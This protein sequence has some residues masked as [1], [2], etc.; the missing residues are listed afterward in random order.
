MTPLEPETIDRICRDMTGDGFP[1]GDLA[2]LRR[3]RADALDPLTLWRNLVRWGVD[4][5]GDAEVAGWADTLALLASAPEVHQRGRH[6]GQA[7]AE[8]GVSEARLLR[9]LRAEGD[10]FA[11]QARSVLHLLASSGESADLS[12]L[13]E[14][15]FA[16][17]PQRRE[18]IC[19]NIASNYYRHKPKE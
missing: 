15:R 19:R 11:A 7:L 17:S 16:L 12:F 8:A 13:A 1:P 14:L 5:R 9:L 2:S 18:H 10:A 6:L 4:P 3:L